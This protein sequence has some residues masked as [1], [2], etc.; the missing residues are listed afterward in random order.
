MSVGVSITPLGDRE[1]VL[2]QNEYSQNTFH[3][4]RACAIVEDGQFA[5]GL[6]RPDA[7]NRLFVGDDLTVA[8]GDHEQM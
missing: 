8:V 3:G 6:P 4:R 1:S 5:K 7:I 2:L